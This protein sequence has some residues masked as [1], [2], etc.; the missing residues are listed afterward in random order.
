MRAQNKDGAS[1]DFLNSSYDKVACTAY[2]VLGLTLGL[3]SV[4]Q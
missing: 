2:L 4:E 1:V 3:P